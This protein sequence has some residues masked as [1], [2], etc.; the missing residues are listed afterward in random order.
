MSLKEWHKRFNIIDCNH[1]AKGQNRINMDGEITVNSI[2]NTKLY[3]KVIEDLFGGIRIKDIY[4]NNIGNE[5]THYCSLPNNCRDILIKRNIINGIHDNMK[6]EKFEILNKITI[7]YYFDPASRKYDSNLE[8]IGFNKKKIYNLDL[9]KYGLTNWTFNA[10]LTNGVHIN[11]TV[12]NMI[13]KYKYE[14]TVDRSGWI[15]TG[16]NKN[17]GDRST[18]YSYIS[19]NSTKNRYIFQN[20]NNT[21]P[22]IIEEATGYVICKLL[23]DF[24]HIWFCD[25]N[26]AVCTSDIFMLKRCLAENKNCIAKCKNLTGYQMRFYFKQTNTSPAINTAVLLDQDLITTG[27]KQNGGYINVDANDLHD[28]TY[29]TTIIDSI[30]SV[31]AS[32]NVELS[33]IQ[34]T[35]PKRIIK[36]TQTS[37]ETYST[38]TAT[39]N[40]LDNPLTFYSD[41]TFDDIDNNIDNNIIMR[42]PLISTLIGLLFAGVIYMN[43]YNPFRGGTKSKL[44]EQDKWELTEN[45]FD[46]DYTILDDNAMEVELIK[47]EALYNDF[48]K[49][50]E[51][52][53]KNKHTKM[54]MNNKFVDCPH[55]IY[56]FIEMLKSKLSSKKAFGKLKEKLSK[57]KIKMEFNEEIFKWIPNNLFFHNDY[58]KTTINNTTKKNED[59]YIP[60]KITKLFPN[61]DNDIVNEIFE[62]NNEFS[63]NNTFYN[64]VNDKINNV[65]RITHNTTEKIIIQNNYK[66]IKLLQFLDKE[67]SL[68]FPNFVDKKT[69]VFANNDVNYLQQIKYLKTVGVTPENSNILY[70]ILIDATDRDIL[71]GHDINLEMLIEIANGNVESGFTLYNELYPYLSVS[72]NYIL[73]YEL[74]TK[75]IEY[76]QTNERVSYKKMVSIDILIQ[77]DDLKNILINQFKKN[78]S[79]H[80]SIH[81]KQFLE[82]FKQNKKDFNVNNIKYIGDCI[83][84]LP[85]KFIRE[86]ESVLNKILDKMKFIINEKHDT[87]T[88]FKTLKVNTYKNKKIN[89]LSKGY[90][91]KK[92]TKQK[93]HNTKQKTKYQTKSNKKYARNQLFSAIN[94]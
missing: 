5:T 81:E 41:Y 86:N 21:T 32:K 45:I 25:D 80:E 29:G 2:L 33:V 26:D 70:R 39:R 53:L 9:T 44:N 92:N 85:F 37:N 50:T 10:K 79:I 3:K 49:K 34:N 87:P 71:E 67:Y 75:L 31:H 74:F 28:N 1:D 61:L 27:G 4:P 88:I 20:G 83:R 22:E 40:T 17:G 62:I 12:Q 65:N 63:E 16:N 68:I 94:I 69:Q 48:I 15:I 55:K 78:E 47:L 19:G 84:V 52:F 6:P 59:F 42:N 8:I 73:R 82:L 51:L 18:D 11:F 72:G 30:N 46:Y 43:P 91:T 13:N 93:T 24:S 38:P 89:K 76:L 14:T 35:I 36:S 23:G 56:S 77:L 7:S 64:F 58:I 90:S 66:F 57:L 54:K 60:L